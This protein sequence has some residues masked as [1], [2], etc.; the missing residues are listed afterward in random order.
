M[1]G[2]NTSLSSLHKAQFYLNGELMLVL[3]AAT[4][5]SVPFIPWLREKSRRVELLRQVTELACLLVVFLL[6]AMKLA[7]GTYNP[8]IYFRF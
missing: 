8:F 3:C 1:L 5:G 2:V 7:A 6:C 4:L